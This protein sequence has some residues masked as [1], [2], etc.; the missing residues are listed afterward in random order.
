[1]PE[2]QG[3]SE[4]RPGAVVR[5]ERLRRGWTLAEA[6]ARIGLPISTLS[7]VENDKISLTYDKLARLSRGLEIDISR[8]FGG[9][10]APQANV[11]G[12][13]SVTKAGG[14][15][16]IETRNYGHLYIA[17][18]L[19][20]KSFIPVVAEVRARSLE[21]FGELV[22]HEGEEF[23]FVLEGA[24]DLHT[25][26]YAPVRLEAGDSIYFDSGMGHAYV[27][28]SEGPCRVLSICTGAEAQLIAAAEG[29]TAER[30]DMPAFR[31][32]RRLANGG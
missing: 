12:R 31:I 14:G 4:A 1:M 28:V 15:R 9:Q 3:R 26:V 7:K 8:L 20:N 23:A 5:E 32:Q 17:A 16:A 29:L 2:N 22:R 13:R 6:S 27:A 10:D 24:V 11:S 21:E 25:S 18:D 19:L 30:G